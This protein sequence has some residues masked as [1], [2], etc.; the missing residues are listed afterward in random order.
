[1]SKKSYHHGDL[2]N[3]LISAAIEIVAQEGVYGLTLRKA[4]RKAG[5]SHNAPY[6]HFTDKQALIAAIAVD[7][8]SKIQSLISKVV[9][10]YPN[11]PL[12]QLVHLAWAYV[13]FGL[14][15]PAHYKITFSGLIE[16]EKNYPAFVEVSQ[17]SMSA[18]K[19]ITADCQSAGILKKSDYEVEMVAVSMWGLIHGLVSLVIEGQVSSKLLMR[20]PPKAML[21]ATLQQVV[22][23]PLDV[24]ILNS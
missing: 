16:N 21:I 12:Q 13:Q 11:D 14:R 1:M 20:N 15:S 19:K 10:K 4:A 23:V 3:A 7:G 24:S 17:L 6:A 5:V 18:I 9:E 2:K 22:C 8:H